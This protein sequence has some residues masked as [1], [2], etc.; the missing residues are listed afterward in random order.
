MNLYAIPTDVLLQNV[1]LYVCLPLWVIVGFADYLCHRK[2]G[3]EHT[4]GIRESLFHVIMGAQM[5]L[6]V[7]LGLFF[8]I[9]VLLLLLAFAL[10]VFHVWVAHSDVAYAIDTRHITVWETHTHSFLE[11]LP[12]VVLLLI[13]CKKWSAF[14]DLV[15]L[16]WSGNMALLPRADP[17]DAHYILGY[18]LLMMAAGVAP[19]VEEMWRCWNMRGSLKASAQPARESGN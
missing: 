10:L 9:N 14:V 16:N 18:F 12:F 3:I 2:S 17:I 6:P 1:I 15:T 8:E 5:G 11:V 19:Y 13:V 7:F 4:T